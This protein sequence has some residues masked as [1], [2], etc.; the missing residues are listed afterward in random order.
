MK[1]LILLLS[2]FIFLIVALP[3]ES[4][5]LYWRN[6]LTGGGDCLD[7]IDGASL[8][9]GDGAFVI[10]D[11]SGT[12]EGYI[13]RLEDTAETESSPN[14]IAPD[15]NAGNKR[16]RLVNIHA[17]GFTGPLTGAV[18]GNADTATTAT[19]A[20]NLKSPATTGVAQLTGMGAGTTRVKTVRDANDT[21]VEAGGD[22][23]LSGANTLS[24][25]NSAGGSANVLTLSGTL[26]TMDGSDIF[27]GIYIW[28][29]NAASHTGTDYVNGIA[30]AD[31]VATDATEQAIY[32]GS[33]WDYGVDSRSPVKISGDGSTTKGLLYLDDLDNSAYVAITPADVTTTYTLTLPTAA[34][35]ED[36]SVMSFATD[37]TSTFVNLDD[38]AASG[39]LA[40]YVPL[41]TFTAAGDVPVGSGSGAVTKISSGA[42]SISTDPGAN[43][44]FFGVNNAGTLGFHSSFNPVFVS[45]PTEDENYSGTIMSLAAA[46]NIDAYDVVY[47]TNNS[48]AI[49]VS[50][51]DAGAVAAGSR[52]IGIAPSA[53]TSGNPGNILTVG[54]I[55][56]DAWNFTTNS[57]EGKPVYIN[58]TTSAI[59][60]TANGYPIVG[61]VLEAGGE[62]GPNVVYFNFDNAKPGIVKTEYIP[63]AY[64]ENGAAA[65]AT[66]SVWADTRKARV[67]E[68]AADA[69]DD[70]EIHWL[71]PD[72]YMSGIKFRAIG[73]VTNATAPANTETVIFNLAGCSVGNSD[74]GGCTLGTGVTSTFT[75][76]ATYAQHDRW[77]SSW[78]NAITVTDITAGESVML[79][80]FRDVDDTYGQAIGLAGI[81]IKY[82]A[83]EK[84]NETY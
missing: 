43:N 41:S 16:W 10:R 37:G 13:Y 28:Y 73:F 81:E 6:C 61:H 47:L 82:I 64:M 80:L 65:P 54:T 59:T 56:N 77:S 21:I 22:N 15:S 34:P 51:Y 35:T 55:R 60:L 70:V 74:D 83:R 76:D 44:T 33:G 24:K 71:A 75:A 39:D 29:I 27:R 8:A 45:A 14:V 46:E 20:E 49:S 7:G 30:I 3:A 69:D 57:D 78:S 9:D 66:A 36:N 40:S 72:D 42:S 25:V 23:T 67:R 50:L 32:V 38:Y 18:T 12:Y 58:L 53:I 31:L 17:I 68:F 62:S 63:V 79:K 19:T 52:P 5:N 1:K 26:G 2:I 11:N 48:G 4:A 84:G